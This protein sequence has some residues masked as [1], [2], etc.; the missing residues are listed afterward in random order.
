MDENTINRLL[1]QSFL[2]S[3]GKKWL[4]WI[5]KCVE[6]CLCFHLNRLPARGQA[7]I[8]FSLCRFR[9]WR[10]PLPDSKVFLRPD[11]GSS[12][13]VEANF[14]DV[15]IPALSADRRRFLSAIS[16]FCSPNLT[17]G[18]EKKK[19]QQTVRTHAGWHMQRNSGFCLAAEDKRS[20][21][22]GAGAERA[23]RQTTAGLLLL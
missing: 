21:L 15:F 2:L 10:P 14:G 9:W 18:G 16:N 23:L 5:Q 6:V 8:C 20:S 22:C 19:Y 11:C 4:K 1:N 13:G 3:E 17:D 7:D 12:R